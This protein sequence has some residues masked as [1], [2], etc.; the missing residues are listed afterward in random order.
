MASYT[1][2]WTN[3][4]WG[5]YSDIKR[6]SG[7]CSID[8]VAGDNKRPLSEAGPGDEIFVV[9]VKQGSLYVA[10]RLVVAT[11]P[12]SR[13]EAVTKLG[14]SDLIDKDMFFVAN[15]DK[16]DEFRSGCLVDLELAKNLELIKVDGSIGHPS[17]DRKGSIDR[18]AFRTPFKL[19]VKSAETLR[20]ILSKSTVPLR[21]KGTTAPEIGVQQPPTTGDVEG[22]VPETDDSG[23]SGEDQPTAGVSD[24]E[25][26]PD[27]DE[28]KR[29][30]DEECAN[31]EGQDVDAVVKRRVGQGVFRNL[32][33]DDFGRACCMTGLKNARLLIASHIV[34]W[35]ESAP[36][37][38]LAPD[39]GL[40][41]SVSMDA[42]FDKGLISFADNGSILIGKNLDAETI[43]ILGLEREFALPEKILTAA[44]MKNLAKHRERHGFDSSLG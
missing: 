31:L 4:T 23:I 27:L 2:L 44:R 41:L 38:K 25:P 42:L 3:E 20:S 28:I 8:Y 17:L 37:Q 15:K 22:N 40:L 1:L 43:E 11:L 33:L 24:A 13:H 12:L 14:R 19:T 39:N 18:Q 32:L 5:K 7:T 26:A 36:A 9:T 10:G 35:S 34:P 6:I 21:L 30:I 16:L 29:K